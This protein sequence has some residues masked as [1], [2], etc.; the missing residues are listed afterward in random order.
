MSTNA[1]QLRIYIFGHTYIYIIV[2]E[3]PSILYAEIKL[4]NPV[5][6]IVTTPLD[7]NDSGPQP[8]RFTNKNDLNEAEI[9]FEGKFV[10][11]GIPPTH[12]PNGENHYVTDF[13]YGI[14]FGQMTLEYFKGK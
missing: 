2:T 1:S 13:K 6:A 5:H 12:D 11:S 9:K 8:V 4:H 14:V 3:E 10:A 7:P